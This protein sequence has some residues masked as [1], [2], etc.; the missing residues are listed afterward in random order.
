M[1]KYH[2]VE[3][4]EGKLLGDDVGCG[5]CGGMLVISK[6]EL[7]EYIAQLQYALDNAQL[8]LYEFRELNNDS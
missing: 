7:L 8:T 2:S 5:C 4:K 6:N 1:I 3:L